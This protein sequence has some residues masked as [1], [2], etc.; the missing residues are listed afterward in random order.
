MAD[1]FREVEEDLR[2]DNLEK[3][4]KKYGRAGI[5][6]AVAVVV[7]VAGAQIWRSYELKQHQEMSNRFADAL[8]QA[9]IKSPSAALP[10][11]TALAAEGGGYASLAA[12]ERARVLAASGDRAGAIET[13]ESIA[14]DGDVE[15]SFRAVATLMA[16]LH[17]IDDGDPA[18]LRTRLAPL[19]AEGSAFRGSALELMA[20]LALREDDVASARDFYTQ[21]ADDPGSPSGLRARAAQMLAALKE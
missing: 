7:G 20:V 19:M 10:E 16:V 4:W 3:L 2:R 9:Q 18:D 5:V 12:L 13:W 14:A 1:I 8:R 15:P 11:L 6:A 21:I 17:Q